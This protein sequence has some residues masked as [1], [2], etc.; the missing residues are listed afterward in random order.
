MQH[1]GTNGIKKE[2]MITGNDPSI[3]QSV[4]FYGNG[5]NN[6]QATNPMEYN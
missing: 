5:R 3:A 6:I 4:Q 2:E 1:G